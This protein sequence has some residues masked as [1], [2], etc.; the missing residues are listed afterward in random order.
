MCEFQK[1][2]D[3][4]LTIFEHGLHCEQN[5]SMIALYPICI[6][7]ATTHKNQELSQRFYGAIR[8]CMLQLQQLANFVFGG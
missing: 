1:Y 5:E 3:G 6:A 8:C 2:N 4:F 7:T